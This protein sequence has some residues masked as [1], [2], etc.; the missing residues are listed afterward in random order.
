MK[1]HPSQIQ[2][3]FE[4]IFLLKTKAAHGEWKPITDIT[5]NKALKIIDPF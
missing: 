2:H 5:T 1:P 4:I 3:G